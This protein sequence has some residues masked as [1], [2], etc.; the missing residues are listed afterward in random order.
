[1]HEALSDHKMDILDQWDPEYEDVRTLSLGEIYQELSHLNAFKQ[2]I[3]LKQVKD[4]PE[5]SNKDD[6]DDKHD[7]DDK[8]DINAGKDSEQAPAQENPEKT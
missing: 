6:K 5:H 4:G 8:E 2:L 3:S 7:K 1:M